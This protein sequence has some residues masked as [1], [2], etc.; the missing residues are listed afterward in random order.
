MKWA[1]VVREIGFWEEK[2]AL[3]R[4]CATARGSRRGLF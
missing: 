4:T 2:E 1:E 3:K